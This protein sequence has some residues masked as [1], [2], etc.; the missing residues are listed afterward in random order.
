[1]IRHTPKRYRVTTIVALVGAALFAT[2][3]V[4]LADTQVGQ[5]GHYVFKEG[6][7]VGATCVYAWSNGRYK[8]T[9]IVV[10]APK[11]WWPDTTAE[12]NR[13]HGTVGW[14]LTVQISNPG[15]YGPWH[16]LFSSQEIRRRAFEDQPPYDN[17]DKAR[18]P[19]MTLFIN[20][21]YKKKPNAHARV[22]HDAY[23]YANGSTMGQV[24]HEQFNY[25]IQGVPGWTSVTTACPIHIFPL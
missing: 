24:T 12:N 6:S 7:P 15:A 22:I 9:R 17:A 4:A 3:G 19:K 14:E 11:L 20:G 1:M 21:A 8:L 18:L 23:W 16:D 5:V 2:S 13:E 25:S 10:N